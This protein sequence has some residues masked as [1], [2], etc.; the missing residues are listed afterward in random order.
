[1][2]T[3]T[4][5]VLD[6]IDRHGGLPSEP[7]RP[8]EGECWLF[9]SWHNDAGYPYVHF[10]GRD[11]PAHRVVW[12][13]L[14]GDLTEGLELDHVC[15]NRPCVNPAHHEEVTRAENL[16]RMSLAQTR[17]R[18]VGHDWSDPRNVDV[19]R[20]GTRTCAECRRI[21]ARERYRAS[22]AGAAA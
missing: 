3:R 5:R 6:Q 20:N 2:K 7:L 17:C 14:V 16:R 12:I 13:L 8:V 11:Q 1:M 4:R 9:D 10:D 15:R 19:R 22:T 21:N 18:K